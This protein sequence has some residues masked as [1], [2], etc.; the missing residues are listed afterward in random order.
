MNL[1]IVGAQHCNE[2]LR[3]LGNVYWLYLDKLVDTN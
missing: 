2:P 1:L 3:W